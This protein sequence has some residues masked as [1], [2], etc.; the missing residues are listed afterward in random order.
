[1]GQ[2]SALHEALAACGRGDWPRVERLCR[3]VL[4]AQP[5]SFEALYL[6]G[7]AAGQAGRAA[8]AADF[9]ERAIAVN[10]AH[11]DAHF[12]R[13]VALASLGRHEEAAESYARVMSL[14][15]RHADACF[16]R[17]VSL[18]AAGRHG[19]ALASYD[20]ALRLAPSN[21]EAHHNRG[22]ALARMGRHE[23]AL[24]SYDA[25]LRVRPNAPSVH[26]SRGVALAALDRH[27]EALAAY[28]A[29]ISIRPD[30]TAAH[31]NLAIALLECDRPAESLEACERAI[32]LQP[33]NAEA[34]FN[35]GNALRE[36]N[37]HEQAIASYERAIALDPAHASAHWNL[38]DCL[39]LTGS[40]Q[41]GWQEYE[42]R[43]KLPARQAARR[44]F[45]QPLWLGQEP[46][47]GRTILLHAELG[48]GDTLQFC[49]YVPLLAARG[50][51]VVLEVQPPLVPLLA[52]LEG[53]HQVIARG[54]SLPA[55]D[56]HCPIM[57]LPLA[58][59]T[60]ALDVPA[61]IPY[62]ACDPA[63][64]DRWRE[65]LGPR[66]RPRVGLVWS[67]SR[68][69]RNDKRSMTL[70]Q[71]LPMLDPAFEW[72]SLQREVAA[73]DSALLERHPEVRHFGSDLIDFAETAA[74]ASLL[75]L[76]VTVD[77]SVAHLAGALGKPLWILLPL[78]QHD[79]RWQLQREDSPWYPQAW[80]VRQ[81]GAGDWSGVVAGVA[82]AL[83]P[84]FASPRTGADAPGL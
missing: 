68:G 42:W 36:L 44:D 52:K 16:N 81:Q 63:R 3:Q 24:A 65:R 80:L 6:L 4:A 50:A 43:W 31:C 46:L 40:F 11:P 71:A 10:P 27:G 69:L 61:N 32:A 37:R 21:P 77:T 83:R 22:V 75:D 51:R 18:A 12:N 84:H 53:A 76:V 9:L 72:V 38:A 28:A 60:D 55:F 64:V 47:G 66:A 82:A 78:N 54:A 33:G 59:R 26:N 58:F 8:E 30:F 73:E 79:W 35:R 14:A 48:L 67:G 41:R 74:L 17:G 1:M 5:R 70:R 34:W 7:V 57:S 13:G 56:C 39:L 19:E 62:I 29:A 23:E 2:N 49:R 15:P 20:A 45:P 25:A